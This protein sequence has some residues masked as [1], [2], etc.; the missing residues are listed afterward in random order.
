MFFQPLVDQIVID[1]AYLQVSRAKPCDW[2]GKVISSGYQI[3]KRLTI[4]TRRIVTDHLVP[5]DVLVLAVTTDPSCC[6]QPDNINAPL[7][8]AVPDKIQCRWMLHASVRKGNEGLIRQ[9][10]IV[11]FK[12][13]VQH[14]RRRAPP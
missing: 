14:V 11:C 4:S 9:H 5:I 10:P 7:L 8:A 13:L 12:R 6:L 2:V 3:R 1:S